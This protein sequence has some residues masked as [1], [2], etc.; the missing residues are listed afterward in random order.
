MADVF[1]LTKPEYEA[2]R[3][4]LAL[5]F[6]A[7]KDDLKLA[8]LSDAEVVEKTNGIMLALMAAAITAQRRND[9]AWLR[10][11]AWY[12]EACSLMLCGVPVSDEPTTEH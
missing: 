8:E 5:L 1:D 2:I 11:H 6:V 7:H 4:E 3:T 10:R 12:L 9:Q